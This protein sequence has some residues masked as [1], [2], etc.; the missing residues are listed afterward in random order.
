MKQRKQK[1]R[2]EHRAHFP[3]FSHS[4][5]DDATENQLFANCWKNSEQQNIKHKPTKIVHW[6]ANRTRSGVANEFK[7]FVNERDEIVETK[8]T[9]K[10]QANCKKWVPPFH[11]EF[12]SARIFPIN[13]FCFVDHAKI[14]K[15]AD[16]SNRA[17]NNLHAKSTARTKCSQNEID[18][19]RKKLWHNATD[20]KA[21][22][23]VV[24][25]IIKFFV[26]WLHILQLFF[27][28]FHKPILA[29]NKNI[30]NQFCII[31]KS[32]V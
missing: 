14:R 28:C 5:K 19:D 2:K 17:R 27:V 4:V 7:S 11:F 12:Y 30:S 6:N 16:W 8:K 10:P 25:I 21:K 18:D 9:H 20:S 1:R 15:I 22:P 23:A 13:V 26:D 31:A 32:L 24:W 29:H 3:H